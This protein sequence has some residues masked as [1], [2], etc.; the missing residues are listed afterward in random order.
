MAK[1][2]ST[3]KEK[4]VS[5]TVSLVGRTVDVLREIED[6]ERFIKRLEMRYVHLRLEQLKSQPQKTSESLQ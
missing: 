3:S 4:A 6:Y 5:L 2:S 1:N